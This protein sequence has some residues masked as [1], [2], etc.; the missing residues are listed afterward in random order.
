M[1]RAY[2]RGLKSAAT[3]G[4][5]TLLQPTSPSAFFMLSGIQN[6]AEFQST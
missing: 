6:Y 4:V 1:E 5:K 3:T 2:L